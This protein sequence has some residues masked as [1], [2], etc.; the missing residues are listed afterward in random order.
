MIMIITTTTTT[1]TEK[2]SQDVGE[3]ARFDHPEV[4]V[5]PPVDANII[6]KISTVM[7]MMMI[8]LMLIMI[9]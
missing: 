3:I 9:W 7:M 1:T 8:M 4:I 6:I 2:H 5:V